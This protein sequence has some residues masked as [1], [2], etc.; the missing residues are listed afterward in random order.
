MGM[1]V[2]DVC[3]WLICVLKNNFYDTLEGQPWLDKQTALFSTHCNKMISSKEGQTKLK[4]LWYIKTEMDKQNP[5]ILIVTTTLN[6]IYI[7][8]EIINN[9]TDDYQFTQ[10][11]LDESWTIIDIVSIFQCTPEFVSNLGSLLFNLR[12]LPWPGC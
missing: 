5:N 1:G 3:A 9:I 11:L 2:G 6:S 10:S 12:G 4:I 8:P 7:A